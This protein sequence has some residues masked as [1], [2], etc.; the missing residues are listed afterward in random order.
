MA[1]DI[2]GLIALRR[3]LI[4]GDWNSTSA[5]ERERDPTNFDFHTVSLFA[6]RRLAAQANAAAVPAALDARG[7]QASD[8]ILALCCAP[9]L[10]RLY[11][12][13]RDGI[14]V[15][16]RP[17][18]AASTT[19]WSDGPPAKINADFGL[20]G[21]LAPTAGAIFSLVRWPVTFYASRSYCRQNFGCSASTPGAFHI[22]G[23]AAEYS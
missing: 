14:F 18:R 15:T 13:R 1:F 2:R 16:S 3:A 17:R 19:R 7:A 5:R 9:E 12:R 4:A 6:Q 11:S 23:T 8:E 21:I 20:F 10:H 22:G